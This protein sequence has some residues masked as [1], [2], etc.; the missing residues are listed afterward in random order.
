MSRISGLFQVDFREKI[1]SVLSSQSAGS[2]FDTV[3]LNTLKNKGVR[4]VGSECMSLQA[5]KQLRIDGFLRDHGWDEE[6][7]SLA[8]SHTV[9]RSVY[10]A[11][12]LKTV[13][14]MKENSSICEFTGYPVSRLTKDKLYC[15]SKKM[16]VDMLPDHIKL[17]WFSLRH[18]IEIATYIPLAVRKVEIPKPNGGVRMLGIPC[19]IDRL[20]QQAIVQVLSLHY[21]DSFSEFSYGFRPDR[22]A[23][24]AVRQAQLYLNVGYIHVI[25]LDLE[26]LF[27]KVNHNKLMTLLSNRITDKSLLKLIRRYLRTDIMDVV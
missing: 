24:D 3:D 23:H 25:E 16:C 15:I 6:N 17:N 2:D 12:E 5:L 21:D 11:P 10:P 14:F 22:C 18:Q 19:V 20:I 27:Y 7:I 8:L 4:E 1:D 13:S 9:S 26:K